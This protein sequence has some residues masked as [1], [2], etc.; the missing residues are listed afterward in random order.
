MSGGSFNYLEDR[1][2]STEEY[3][4]LFQA[5]HDLGVDMNCAAVRDVVELIQKMDEL[6][7]LRDRIAPFI[8]AVEWCCSGDIG[9]EDVIEA[10]KK[11][12]AM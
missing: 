3:A 12:E 4:R 2:G 1:L 7:R 6:E 8:H 10:V 9:P 11:Y 5:A